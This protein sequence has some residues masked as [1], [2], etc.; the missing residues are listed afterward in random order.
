MNTEEEKP[1]PRGI[2][3]N[4][5]GNLRANP[6]IMWKHQNGIDADGFLIFDDPVFGIRA[7]AM[8]LRHYVEYNN[9]T[10]IATMIRKFAPDT[11]NDTEAYIKAVA[12]YTGIGPYETVDLKA[13]GRAIVKAII[14]HEN[15]E[16]PYDDDTIGQ[17]IHLSHIQ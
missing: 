7:L 3:N 2:R 8:V 17:G 5:P 12:E 1:Q 16:Q 10:M 15:G 14:L 11:E 9:L 13:Q 4:N 6:D